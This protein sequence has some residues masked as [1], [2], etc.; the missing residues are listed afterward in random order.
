MRQ[1]QAGQTFEISVEPIELCT[2]LRPVI[3]PLKLIR[4]PKVS[5]GVFSA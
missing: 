4:N 3:R 5:T 2:G 1:A